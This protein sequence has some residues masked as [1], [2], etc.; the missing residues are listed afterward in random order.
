MSPWIALIILGVNTSL[1]MEG[2]RMRSCCQKLA[3]EDDVAC[4]MNETNKLQIMKFIK[5]FNAAPLWRS[6]RN[7]KKLPN[8]KSADVEEKIVDDTK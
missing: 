6:D 7:T 5:Q 4:S 8:F 2:G 1:E 3:F